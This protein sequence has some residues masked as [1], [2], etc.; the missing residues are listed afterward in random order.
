MYSG[1]IQPNLKIGIPILAVGVA[2]IVVGIVIANP[3]LSNVGFLIL[4]F[5][6]S[7]I[8][9]QRRHRW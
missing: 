7:L 3:L 4:I 2:L 5:V 9:R 6:F 8:F 1:K